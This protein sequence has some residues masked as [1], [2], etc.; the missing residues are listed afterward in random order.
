MEGLVDSEDE[1]VFEENLHLLVLKWKKRDSDCDSD[2]GK[3]AEFCAWLL[4]NKVDVIRNT[5][6]RQVR[7]EAG[8]GSPPEPFSTN[9]SE[10]VNSIIK[11]KVEYKR[12][13]LPQFIQKLRELC[14]EQQRE[15]ERAIVG[16][17]KY[18]LRPQYSHFGVAE[19]KWFV[20]SQEQRR[21]H[22]KLF[23][24]APVSNIRNPESVASGSDISSLP[25]TVSEDTGM[26]ASALSEKLMSLSPHLSLPAAA[27][28]AIARKAA[29]ILKT[30][31]GIAPAPGCSGIAQNL[32]VMSNSGKR[33]HM[34]VQKK[35]GS[36]ICDSDCPQYQSAAVCSHVVAAAIHIKQFDNF[37]ASYSNVKRMPNLTKLA[38]CEMPKGRGRKGGKAPAKRKTSVA[39]EQRIR[40]DLPTCSSTVIT[41]SP[42]VSPYVNAP[43]A[44]AV[45]ISPSFH[46]APPYFPSYPPPSMDPFSNSQHPFR[47]HFVT[48][49]I[50]V[51]HGCKGRYHKDLGPPHDL[52]VQHEEWRTFTVSGSTP[53]SRFSNVYYHANIACIFAVWPSFVMSSL[54]VPPDVLVRLN[55]EH[56][57]WL[58]SQFGM[59]ID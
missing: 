39:V 43:S 33:P 25:S 37:I 56:K 57:Q 20:M 14:E 51:C 3:I 49:N 18:R 50:S 31:N 54:V 15:V 24:E 19:S 47:I 10:C 17:G 26:S 32:M 29:E 4:K 5:M 44:S 40:M 59:F 34:V 27:I 46:I 52:C 55:Y 7:E 8:L 41:Q 58:Y 6:L 12:N 16:R 42:T 45:D 21:K 13:E 36:L 28:E 11:R 48:G 38:K 53:Q 1:H 22:L 35:N 2:C 9:A 30:D 23:N